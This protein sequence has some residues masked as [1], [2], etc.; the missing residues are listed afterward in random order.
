MILFLG[1]ADQI[2]DWDHANEAL[3]G[4]HIALMVCPVSAHEEILTQ[5]FAYLPSHPIII[6]TAYGQ[7]GFDWLARKLLKGN[8]KASFV[9][10][11]AMKHYPFLCKAVEYGK[12][13]NLFGRYPD[14]R[15]AVSPYKPRNCEAVNFFLDDI[16]NKR[17]KI[18]TDFI[19]ATLGAT[20]QVSY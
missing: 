17:V 18:V 3:Q 20:N 4:A 10:L 5:L 8:P 1:A 2:F 16:F 15:C 14:L 7:G 11:F 12:S 13:V 19:V 9:T 6:G